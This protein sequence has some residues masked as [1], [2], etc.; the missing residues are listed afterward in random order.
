MRQET[1]TYEDLENELPPPRTDG[2]SRGG[3]RGWY[4]KNRQPGRLPDF[5]RP[6]L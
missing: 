4:P 1:L 5:G 2:L 6:G 3:Y